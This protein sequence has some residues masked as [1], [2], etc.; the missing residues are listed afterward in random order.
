MSN[1]KSENINDLYVET[2]GWDENAGK[3]DKIRKWMYI[4]FFLSIIA[5]VALFII[6]I[7]YALYLYALIHYVNNICIFL[8]IPTF[9]ISLVIY[10]ILRIKNNPKKPFALYSI[11]ASM[12][13]LSL[14]FSNL[15]QYG[16]YMYKVE[17]TKNYCEKLIPLLDSYKNKNGEY[18]QN[19]N[20]L[21]ELPR[22][23]YYL[24]TL[25]KYQFSIYYRNNKS[26]EY[27]F[28][29]GMP[30][31]KNSSYCMYDYRSEIRHWET[32]CY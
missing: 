7:R 15:A 5:N 19:I 3:H 4:A 20:Q 16:W 27:I 8:G 2:D 23:P 30:S 14:F 12:V 17:S 18:P 29:F 1:N 21:G 6:P 9:I 31:L 10:M 32:G 26:G 22:K 24:R 28:S 25:E 13:I 11:L